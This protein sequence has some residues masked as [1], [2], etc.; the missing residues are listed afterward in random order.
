MANGLKDVEKYS[1]IVT[2]DRK[3]LKTLHQVLVMKVQHGVPP[4]EAY[5]RIESWQRLLRTLLLLV[6]ASPYFSQ[7][8]EPFANIY[9]II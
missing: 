9:T 5:Q 6:E 4:N 7:H 2:S 1:D 3:V 8:F